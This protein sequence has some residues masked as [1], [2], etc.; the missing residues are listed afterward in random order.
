MSAQSTP[1]EPAQIKLRKAQIRELEKQRGAI[2]KTFK[3]KLREAQ[4]QCDLALKALAK[5]EKK[6]DAACWKNDRLQD[7]LGKAQIRDLNAINR[8]I[9]ILGGGIGDG[10]HTQPEFLR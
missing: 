10:T 6:Y 7:K 8:R 5:A 1:H 2:I 3:S 4:R 9:R